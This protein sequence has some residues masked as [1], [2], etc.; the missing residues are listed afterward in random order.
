LRKYIHKITK[1]EVAFKVIEYCDEV[2]NQVNDYESI[3]RFYG[4]TNDGEKYYLVT[5]WEKMVI[6]GI[7]L[8]YMEN[9]LVQN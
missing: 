8:N 5:E 9:T 3:I 1:K 6:Y 7:I 4:I 2:R